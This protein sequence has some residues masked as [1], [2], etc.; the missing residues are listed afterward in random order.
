[1]LREGVRGYDYHINGN[2]DNFNVDNYSCLDIKRR[3]LIP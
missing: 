2:K 1:M 3:R